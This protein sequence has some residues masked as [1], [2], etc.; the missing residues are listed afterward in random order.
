MASRKEDKKERKQKKEKKP[1]AEGDGTTTLVVSIDD[2]TRTRDS[3]SL[4]FICRLC[5]VLFV[6]RCC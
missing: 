6:R 4:P 3:V 1:A 2:F 5:L